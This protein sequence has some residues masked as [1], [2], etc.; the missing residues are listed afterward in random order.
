MD[1]TCAPTYERVATIGY[2]PVV[3]CATCGAVVPVRL[4]RSAF[5]SP[6]RIPE[7]SYVPAHRP[8]GA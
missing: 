8:R 4:G 1:T 6:V 2:A 7:G 5:G 3:L